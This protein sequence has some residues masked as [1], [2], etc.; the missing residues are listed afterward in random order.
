MNTLYYDKLAAFTLITNSDHEKDPMVQ[1]MK[2]YTILEAIKK[3]AK[4]GKKSPQ[5]SYMN[6]L[7]KF[8]IQG[9]LQARNE[10][11]M[12]IMHNVHNVSFKIKPDLLPID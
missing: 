1:F 10:T 3:F 2:S 9:Y 6:V 7:I 4:L 11:F 5:T 8:D 12:Q